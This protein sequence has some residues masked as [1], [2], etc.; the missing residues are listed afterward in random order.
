VK[1][2]P[3]PNVYSGAFLGSRKDASTTFTTPS[4]GVIS[5]VNSS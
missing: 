2:K 1:L 3:R 5:V 4:V